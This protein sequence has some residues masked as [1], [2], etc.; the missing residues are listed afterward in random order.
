M[1]EQQRK[2]RQIDTMTAAWVVV[3][4]IAGLFIGAALGLAVS[5]TIKVPRPTVGQWVRFDRAVE[6]GL[7]DDGSV[8]WRKRNEPTPEPVPRPRPRPDGDAGDVGDI[9]TGDLP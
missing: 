8:Q 7:G 9:G 2:R 5:S 1:D 3:A 4:L 6:F